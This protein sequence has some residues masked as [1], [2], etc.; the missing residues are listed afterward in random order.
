MQK[1]K[2]G[3]TII[4]LLVVVAI[5]GLLT[6]IISFTVN[7]S[8]TK[9]RDTRRVTDLKQIKSG[10]DLYFQHGSGYPDTP[11]WNAAVGLQ[12]SCSGT[13][14]LQVPKD[15]VTPTY[16]YLY[17]ASGN[18]FSGCG[19]TV[20]GDYE[21]EFYIE[22]KALYYIMDEDGNLRDKATGS[23]VSFDFLL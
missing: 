15:P 10:L 4:E 8:R 22:N 17:T 20:R 18:S 12:L 1:S 21:L 3:F 6:S 16:Q 9:A 23:P 11:T 5:I 14:I 2:L 19:G 13:N 7:T